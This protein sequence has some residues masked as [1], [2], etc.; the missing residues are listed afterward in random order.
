MPSTVCSASV[1]SSR[2]GWRIDDQK[3]M[4]SRHER[5]GSHA[6]QPMGDSLGQA[7]GPASET[8][9]THLSPPRPHLRLHLVRMYGCKIR[10]QFSCVT[11]FCATA[12]EWRVSQ[13]LLSSCAL[14]TVD[15]N[16][17]YLHAALRLV[18]EAEGAERGG[19]K[20]EKK[21]E[22][23]RRERGDGE[24]GGGGLG[25]VQ[26]RDQQDLETSFLSQ[27]TAWS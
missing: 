17:Y 20:G 27:T 8:G 25:W 13:P 11:T 12:F 18:S 9:D 23:A 7:H 6:V 4:R 15:G 26:R 1:P 10:I 19:E 5:V 21:K 16:I 22:R 2:S 3:E 14:S 24:G